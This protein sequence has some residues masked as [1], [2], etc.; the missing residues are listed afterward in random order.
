[1]ERV[2]HMFYGI[3]SVIV[4]C[5][6]AASLIDIDGWAAVCGWG[7]IR[8]LS[9]SG[10]ILTGRGGINGMDDMRSMME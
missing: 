9:N 2:H 8:Q 4:R 7:K 10:N 1:M 5:L 6:R 3:Y